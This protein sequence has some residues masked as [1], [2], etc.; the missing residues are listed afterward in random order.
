VVS[1]LQAVGGAAPIT[2]CVLAR[3]RNDM[4]FWC[5]RSFGT[6]VDGVGSTLP[7]VQIARFQGKN[8]GEDDEDENESFDL[9]PNSTT[10][11]DKITSATAGEQIKSVRAL[12]QKFSCVNRY[13]NAAQY[14]YNAIVPHYWP[15]P[16]LF[17]TNI[18]GVLLG[19]GSQVYWTWYGHYA[20]M[21][22]CVR[23]GTRWKLWQADAGM[24]GFAVTA[25]PLFMKDTAAAL[26]YQNSTIGTGPGFTGETLHGMQ[27]AGNCG[28]EFT[29]PNYA[30]HLWTSAVDYQWAI[31]PAAITRVDGI[32]VADSS[33]AANQTRLYSAAAPDTSLFMFRRTPS[34][35]GA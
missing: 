27:Q 29:L 11:F 5:P 1:A 10:N 32:F 22:C 21:Y 30:Q 7:L 18:F 35:V 23:G 2:F 15:P 25:V 12:I 6:L 16:F 4:D 20:A 26:I 8:V 3:A 28:V 31:T 13:Y 33:D 14:S 9:V 24:G 17:P 19:S 34:L